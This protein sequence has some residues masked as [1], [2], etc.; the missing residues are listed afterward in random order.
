MIHGTSAKCMYGRYRP[1][2]GIA[3][4]AGSL[5]RHY[6][7]FVNVSAGA[8]NSLSLFSFL[9]CFQIPS[10]LGSLNYGIVLERD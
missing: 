5:H 6:S 1:M 8:K 2:S 3:N 4:T 7:V 10:S 9:Q